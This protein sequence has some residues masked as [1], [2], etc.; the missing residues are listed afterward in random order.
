MRLADGHS[1]MITFFSLHVFLC[2]HVEASPLKHVGGIVRVPHYQLQ[3]K[4]GSAGQ[5]IEVPVL[6][7]NLDEYMY[8]LYNY[9]TL[10]IKKDKLP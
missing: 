10:Y 5:N 1:V 9:H 7:I 6:I 3:Q 2:H 4:T 8:T